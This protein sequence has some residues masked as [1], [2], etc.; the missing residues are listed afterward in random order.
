MTV[1]V[2]GATDA[3]GMVIDFKAIKQVLK[4][5]VEAWDHATLVHSGDEE[6]LG[7]LRQHGWKHFV[8]PFD[9]TSENVARFAADYLCQ[10]AGDALRTRGITSVR[11]CLQETETCYAT[12]A[13]A[14][15]AESATPPHA[16]ALATA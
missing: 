14:V 5:L 1:E 3:Q 9:S 2:E 8:L 4:P 15:D 12:Y 16:L 10:E 7:M 6:L 11:V 13:R